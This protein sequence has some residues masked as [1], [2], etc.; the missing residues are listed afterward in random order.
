[1]VEI[2]TQSGLVGLG[3]QLYLREGFRTTKACLEEIIIPRIMGR[4]A[5]EI[6]GHLAR[7]LHLDDC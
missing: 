4:D 7:H 2:E 5:S 1:M 3:Y 6:E